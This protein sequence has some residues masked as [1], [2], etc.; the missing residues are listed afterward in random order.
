MI[1]D[2]ASAPIESHQCHDDFL[3]LKAR[4]ERHARFAF[5]HFPP[6]EREE[7]AYGYDDEVEEQPSVRHNHRG[8]VRHLRRKI[9]GVLARAFSLTKLRSLGIG[10]RLARVPVERK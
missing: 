1:I 9:G 4:V 8:R 2:N 10:F 7:A 5:R 3:P 6:S